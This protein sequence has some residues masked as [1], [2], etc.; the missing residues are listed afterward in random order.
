[1]D[2][3]ILSVEVAS[4]LKCIW[5]YKNKKIR[6]KT[7]YDLFYSQMRVRVWPRLMGIDLIETN[8]SIPSDEQVKV[9]PEYN[10]GVRIESYIIFRNDARGF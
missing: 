6:Q 7:E 5:I 1:M 8:L 3:V 9:H 4:S 10:Q 2:K